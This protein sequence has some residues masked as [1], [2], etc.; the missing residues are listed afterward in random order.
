MQYPSLNRR[1]GFNSNPDGRVKEWSRIQKNG[2][3]PVRIQTP[4]QPAPF[5]LTPRA[6]PSP[7]GHKVGDRVHGSFV[8]PS[9]RSRTDV[10]VRQSAAST[11]PWV[12]A[13]WCSPRDPR[14]EHFIS[15]PVTNRG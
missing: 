9:C 10:L 14:T 2:R 13:M 7:D 15:T 5:Q 12:C 4:I 11:R 1:H 6:N 3:G 8:C